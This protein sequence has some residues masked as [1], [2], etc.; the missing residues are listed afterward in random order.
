MWRD[1]ALVLGCD[2]VAS[3][4][5]HRLHCDGFGVVVIDR[6]DP[7]V[8]R[9]GMAFVDAWYYGTAELSGVHAVFCASLRSIPSALR[10]GAAIAATTWSWSGVARALDPT[11]SVDTREPSRRTP[12]DRAAA[13]GMRTLEI[14]PGAVTAPDFHVALSPPASPSRSTRTSLHAPHGGRFASQRGIGDRVHAGETIGVIDST[15]IVATV[16]GALRGVTARGARVFAGDLVAEIDTRAERHEC[17][18]LDADATRIAAAVSDAVSERSPQ[19][20]P[21]V[22]LR[23]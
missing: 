18:G 8:P 5:A 21:A 13:P 9:R 11:V 17:F 16:T 22:K 2:E 7:S 3:A 4:I 1:V 10:D 15:P 23:R 14:V 12:V 20:T 19:R 6:V